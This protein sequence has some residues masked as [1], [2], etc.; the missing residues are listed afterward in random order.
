MAFRAL[1][2]VT[3]GIPNTGLS[4]EKEALKPAT[5]VIH[6]TSAPPRKSTVSFVLYFFKRQGLLSIMSLFRKMY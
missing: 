4:Q 1:G 6:G 2:G 3:P 5:T